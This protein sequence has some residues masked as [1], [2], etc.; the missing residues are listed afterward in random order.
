MNDTSLRTFLLEFAEGGLAVSHLKKDR[1]PALDG[2]W[3]H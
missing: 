2:G 3:G 1:P